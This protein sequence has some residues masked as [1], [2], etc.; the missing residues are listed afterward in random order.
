M[1]FLSLW[2]DDFG[3]VGGCCLK[4]E[5]RES[6]VGANLS[7]QDSGVYSVQATMAFLHSV[8]SDPSSLN[9]GI[10]NASGVF[11]YANVSEATEQGV[12]GGAKAGSSGYTAVCF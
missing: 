8:T 9:C 2:Q 4:G 11:V 12:G 5:D 3:R 1:G 10:A 6:G 7:A